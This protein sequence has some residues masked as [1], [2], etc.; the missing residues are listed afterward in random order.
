M[1]SSSYCESACRPGAGSQY[2]GAGHGGVGGKGGRTAVTVAGGK[3]YGNELAPLLPGSYGRGDVSFG[4]G[5]GGRIALGVGLTDAQIASLETTGAAEGLATPTSLTSMY[6]V[7]VSVVGGAGVLLGEPGGEGTA[8]YYANL[9][10][11]KVSLVVAI[12]GPTME[13]NAS[14]AAGMHLLDEGSPVSGSIRD[15][16]I[17]DAKDEDRL[18]CTGWTLTSAATGTVLASGSGNTCSYASLGENAILTWAFQEH[19]RLTVTACGNGTVSGTAGEWVPVGSVVSLSATPSEGAAFQA[20]AAPFFLSKA[21]I[22]VPALSFKMEAPLTVHAVFD[23]GRTLAAKTW[24]GAAGGD[25]DTASN[26]TPAGVPTPDDAVVVP[27][28]ST[29]SASRMVAA[30][31]LAIGNG[32]NLSIFGAV[33]DFFHSV[34]TA[35]LTY[36]STTTGGRNA[37]DFTTPDPLM[38]SVA[39]DFSLADGAKVSLGGFGQFCPSTLYVGGN[40]SLAENAKFA[41]YPGRTNGVDVTRATGGARAFVLG[42]TTIAA[43]ATVFS[44]GVLP[45]LTETKGDMAPAIWDIG[46]LTVEAGGAIVSYTGNSQYGTDLGSAKDNGVGGQWYGAGHG[47]VGGSGSSATGASATLNQT[48]GASYDNPYA[49]LL[50]GRYGRYTMV[51]GGVVRIYATDVVLDGTLDASATIRLNNYEAGGSSGGSVLLFADTFKSGATARLVSRG[52]EGYPLNNGTSHNCGGGAGG[53]VA[54]VVGADAAAKAELL[55]TG[56]TTSRSVQRIN[57]L[58]PQTRYKGTVDVSGAAGSNVAATG[59][60]VGGEGTAWMLRFV[61]PSTVIFVQ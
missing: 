20:W 55:A 34:T 53:R 12:D 48:G 35:S 1:G 21:Q 24:S 17:L 52:K 49:P 61:R 6:P 13:Y 38:I 40:F 28:G 58:E 8:V 11:G 33:S 4:G 37:P 19:Y 44:H 23:T 57:L 54:V 51:G 27:A 7:N 41:I 18:F 31:S 60:G 56:D 36:S 29:V 50:P 25:W 15:Y 16:F 46:A 42:A 5:A 30:G 3:A 10:E 2:N 9:P 45:R 47:G 43:N 32:A 14:P 59:A 39:G 22:A 26:W